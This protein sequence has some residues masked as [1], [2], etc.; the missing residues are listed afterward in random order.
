MVDGEKEEEEGIADGEV[1]AAVR[2]LEMAAAVTA[3]AVLED[4]PSRRP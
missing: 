4:P 3:A 2:W 1:V